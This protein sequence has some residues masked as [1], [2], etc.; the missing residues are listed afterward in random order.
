MEDR[1]L[2]ELAAKA[3]GYKCMWEDYEGMDIRVGYQ[4]GMYCEGVGYFNPL[5]DDGDAFRLAVKLGFQ[6]DCENCMAQ[7]DSCTW[8]DA[9]EI[10]DDYFS[11]RLAIV[12]AAAEIGKDLT[13]NNGSA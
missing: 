1:E 6:L 10:D 8:Y 9:S 11:M 4:G 7:I 3:A 12:R 2:L 5:E 13:T